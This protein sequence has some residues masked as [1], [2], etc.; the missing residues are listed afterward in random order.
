M[1]RS[2]RRKLGAVGCRTAVHENA[3]L[4]CTVCVGGRKDLN[5]RRI[6]GKLRSCQLPGGL[7]IPKKASQHIYMR[8]TRFLCPRS[9]GDTTHSEHTG[10]GRLA[11]AAANTGLW[12]VV[13]TPHVHR[14]RHAECGWPGPS[15]AQISMLAGRKHT[16]DGK[17]RGWLRSV[18]H[19]RV[20]PHYNLRAYARTCVVSGV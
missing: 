20:T 1:G 19:P 8:A 9:H 15:C 11:P 7:T 18:A 6:S 13:P 4:H 12:D 3:P 17:F 10:G 14:Q 2:T 16:V 5:H